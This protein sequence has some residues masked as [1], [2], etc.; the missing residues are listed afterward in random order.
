M[1]MSLVDH[2]NKRFIGIMVN[3][4]RVQSN[5]NNYHI[6]RYSKIALLL[7]LQIRKCNVVTHLLLKK[8]L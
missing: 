6:S 7:M 8:T 5:K 1:A 4:I 3:H 2:F